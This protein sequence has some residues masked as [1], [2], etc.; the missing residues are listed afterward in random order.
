MFLIN[1][2]GPVDIVF[3]I[4]AALALALLVGLYFLIP[5]LNSKK[6]AAQRENLRK[7]EIE[8]KSNLQ[9]SQEEREEKIRLEQSLKAGKKEEALEQGNNESEN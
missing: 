5:L 1:S 9:K 4:I 8:F 7:R 6:Y 2:L 3:F